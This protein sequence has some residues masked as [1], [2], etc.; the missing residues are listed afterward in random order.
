M[1]TWEFSF[2]EIE[3]K[4]F[5][6]HNSAYFECCND[7]KGIDNTGYNIYSLHCSYFM[8][9]RWM[10]PFL[11]FWVFIDLDTNKYDVHKIDEIIKG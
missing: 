1:S 5:A 8:C 4:I 10:Y 3:G 11:K 6:K 7:R 9:T 2:K